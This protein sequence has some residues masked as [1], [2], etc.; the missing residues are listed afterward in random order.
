M[1]LKRRYVYFLIAFMALS[2]VS[3]PVVYSYYTGTVSNPN[4]FTCPPLIPCDNT[5]PPSETCSGFCV[6]YI[7]D[8][9]FN[10]PS[11]NITYG[12]TVEWVNLDPYAHTTT[13]DNGSAWNS[14]VIPTGGHYEFNFTGLAPG[15]YN[16]HCN[17]HPFMLGTV[18][19]LPKSNS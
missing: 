11:I 7:Q 14:F 18:T 5:Q 19:V 4:G 3:Y 16:Y 8:S 10:P 13:A 17:I 6:V 12:S 1:V 15:A 9:S 2:A